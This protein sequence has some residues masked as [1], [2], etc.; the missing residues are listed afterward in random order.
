MNFDH[1][2]ASAIRRTKEVSGTTVGTQLTSS[3]QQ[4]FLNAALSNQKILVKK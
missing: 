1:I 3:T 2:T 4:C